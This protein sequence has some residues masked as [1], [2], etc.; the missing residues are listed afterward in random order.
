M[1]ENLEQLQFG[2]MKTYRIWSS[3]LQAGGDLFLLESNHFGAYTYR[4]FFRKKKEFFIDFRVWQ[5][6]VID[7]WW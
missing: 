5:E 2:Y 3:K 4:R 7:S 1:E 6:C